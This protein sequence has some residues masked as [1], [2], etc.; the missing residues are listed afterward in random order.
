MLLIKRFWILELWIA[1][2]LIQMVGN[3]EL[4]YP[5]TVP[6]W[7]FGFPVHL[8]YSKALEPEQDTAFSTSFFCMAGIRNEDA[9][10]SAREPNTGIF[11]WENLKTLQRNEN[12]APITI[13]F[14]YLP[15]CYQDC[16]VQGRL[17]D[18]RG[19]GTF[20][21]ISTILCYVSL[22]SITL[23]YLWRRS[24]NKY[25]IHW[26]VLL[27]YTQLMILSWIFSAFYLYGNPNFFCAGNQGAIPGHAFYNWLW[28]LLESLN[29][30]AVIAFI[31]YLFEWL[32][33][34]IIMFYSKMTLNRLAR[35]S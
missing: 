32:N 17:C 20:W 14:F 21:G 7:N 31:L 18:L 19:K 29:Y 11:L 25:S 35:N 13:E 6:R 22:L 16:L 3:L 30:I 2:F 12:F 33:H 23:R 34:V 15:F 10:D 1:I 5:Y 24:F 28:Y 27:V 26:W 9:F 8:F 4:S